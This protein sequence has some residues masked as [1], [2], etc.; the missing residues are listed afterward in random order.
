[1]TRLAKNLAMVLAVAL[2]PATASAW[3]PQ[4]THAGLAEQAALASRLHKRLVSLGFVGGLFEPLTIPPADAPALASALKLLSPTHGS[5]PDARGRQAAL[6]WLT[7]GAAL[8]DI[9]ASQGANHFFDPTTGAG[10][11]PPRVGLSARL[12]EL[13]GEGSLPDNGVPA[14]DWLTAKTNPFNLD[15]F[16]NQYAKAVSAATPGERSRYMAASLVAAGAMLHVLGDLGAPSRVRGDAAAHLEPLGG[17]PDDLGS[18]F[19]RIAALTYGR[20]G[21]PAPSRTI[22]RSHLR[23]FITSKD[24][25]GLADLIARSYFSPNTLPESTRVSDDI[26]PHLVRPQ[27]AL[28]A[29]LNL[30]AANRDEGTTL[31]SPAGT[32]LARYRVEHDTLTFSVDD[33]CALEQLAVILPEVAA[34][35]AGLLDFLLRGE[36][37]ITVADQI[38]VSGSGLGAGNLEI[39]VED[40]RGVRTSLTSVA[41]P[42][43]SAAAPAT[44]SAGSAATGSDAAAASGS[45]ASDPVNASEPLAKIA[46][47]AAGTR[48][49]AVFRGQDAA[50]EPIVAVGAMPLTH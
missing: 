23:D 26:R 27:P 3:E 20:L 7:A 16:L 34:Y 22:T 37:T 12:R 38:T 15:Q 32:C 45:A 29:R 50:G 28:P 13:L 10:W 31:R 39:L 21:I 11:I 8:A 14:P 44:G 41:V 40:D 30:M 5:V 2:V 18:R 43:A 47:P 4:T 35:E 17:G 25:G 19:E 33:D 9:P 42:G 1:M 6:A 46:P 36:L 49:V 24:G 48:L